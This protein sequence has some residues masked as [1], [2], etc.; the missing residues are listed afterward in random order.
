MFHE[1]RMNPSTNVTERMCTTISVRESWVPFF[2]LRGSEREMKL[3]KGDCLRGLHWARWRCVP[4]I[5][6][7]SNRAASK[8]EPSHV[9]HARLLNE[10]C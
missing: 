7:R 1:D 2:F 8:L 9:C 10:T 3:M 4:A 6:S 5:R